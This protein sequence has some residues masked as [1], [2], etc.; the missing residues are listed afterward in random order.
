MK[1]GSALMTRTLRLKDSAYP[2][3]TGNASQMTTR[4]NGWTLRR[5]TTA[6]SE[7]VAR[8]DLNDPEQRECLKQVFTNTAETART[9][10][11]DHTA[12]LGLAEKY[13]NTIAAHEKKR[14]RHLR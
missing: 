7:V 13:L 3:E 8:H 10:I 2:Y 14:P 12:M 6:M 4:R 9:K 1:P 11:E 5:W